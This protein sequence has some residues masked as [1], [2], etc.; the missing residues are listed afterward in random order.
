[1]PA[2]TCQESARSTAHKVGGHKDGV[3]PAGCLGSHR[4]GT[5]LVADLY[6][7]HT[8]VNE[9]DTGNES[10]IRILKDIHHGPCRNHQ[11]AADEIQGTDSQPADGG[12]HKG[13]SQCPGH[14]AE[15]QH[16]DHVVAGIK[17]RSA[18]FEGQTG[19]ERQET[20]ET[21]SGTCRHHADRRLA[22]EQIQQRLHQAAIR[23]PE[24]GRHVRQDAQHH[25]DADQHHQG[26]NVIHGAPAPVFADN[27]ADHTRSQ[28]TGQQSAHQHPDVTGLVLRQR[29]LRNHRY[30]DLRH[31]RTDTRHQRSRQYATDIGRHSHSQHGAGQ[32]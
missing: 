8:D 32:Q 31:D 25:K 12:S 5:G 16:T 7:L 17:G 23:P 22:A 18:Q 11:S 27:S 1:M 29:E 19:P 26:S 21:E 28:N 14:S 30:E 13:S 4:Q 20:A 10:G 3:H 9:D 6:A 24:I 2:C 15:S